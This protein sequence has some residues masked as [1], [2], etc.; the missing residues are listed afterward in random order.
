MSELGQTRKSLTEHIE[1]AS[2][3]KS[4]HE[5][6]VLDWP[7]GAIRDQ[8]APQ[9]EIST[10]RYR[11]RGDKRNTLDRKSVNRLGSRPRSGIHLA[12]AP[13]S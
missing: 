3:P 11:Q 1:S 6:D 12:D 9:Q 7:L 8:S 5:P 4:G 13:K 2:P 10:R